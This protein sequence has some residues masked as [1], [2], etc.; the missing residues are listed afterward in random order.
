MPVAAFG[1]SMRHTTV[2]Q[3]LWAGLAACAIAAIAFASAPSPAAA[4]V[5]L[6]AEEE[7]AF[8]QLNLDAPAVG[9]PP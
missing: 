3:T 5:M 2:V 9:S 7:I 6:D 8:N 1:G 4:A